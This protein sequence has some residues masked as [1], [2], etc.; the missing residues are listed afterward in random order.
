MTLIADLK[1]VLSLQKEIAKSAEALDKLKNGALFAFT[2][3]SAVIGVVVG[4]LFWIPCA[5]AI[6][7]IIYRGIDFFINYK[8]RSKY[9]QIKFTEA[10]LLSKEFIYG[11]SI[12]DEE[13]EQLSRQ[14][15]LI[16]DVQQPQS[17]QFKSINNDSNI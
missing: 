17:Y 8:K 9:E 1:K 14:I 2:G 7:L 13:K 12:P 6:S 11:A 16:D 15:D 4:G 3:G 10:K 5:M